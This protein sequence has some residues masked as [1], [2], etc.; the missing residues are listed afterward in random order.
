MSIRRA[1]KAGSWYPDDRERLKALCEACFAGNQREPSPGIPVAGIV[2][3]AGLLYSGPVAAE[4]FSALRAAN[5]QTLIL[6]GAVHTMRLHRPAIWATGCWMSPL[7][8]VDVDKEVAQALIDAGAGEAN[9]LPHQG[10]NAIE[11]QIPLIKYAF[12]DVK[13]VPIAVPPLPGIEALGEQVWSVT[14]QRK[15]SIIAIGSTDLTHYGESFGVTPAGSG[16]SALAWARSNDQ[17]LIDLMLALK[18]EDIVST[19]SRDH[20]ACGAGA[21]AASTAF[22]RMAGATGRLLRYTTSH[23]IR[24]E[25]RARS[26]VGYAGI[27]FYRPLE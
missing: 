10:D 5:P 26:F 7:G 4:T 27:L 6:F 19:A 25:E 1:E 17:R 11:L 16:D 12:P 22:A 21:A 14:S 13:I 8:P 23:H 9:E 24:P 18:A 3:H 2:P 20:S 15:K